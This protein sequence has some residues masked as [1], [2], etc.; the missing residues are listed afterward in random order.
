MI[1]DDIIREYKTWKR[2]AHATINLLVGFNRDLI[3]YSRKLAQRNLTTAY[4]GIINEI[5]SLKWKVQVGS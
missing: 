3:K 2:L 5:P 1:N 4:L